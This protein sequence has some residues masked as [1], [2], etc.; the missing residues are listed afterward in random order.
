MASQPMFDHL[1]RRFEVGI[2]LGVLDVEGRSPLDVDI[3]LARGAVVGAATDQD[4]N[5]VEQMFDGQTG[6][7]AGGV[8]QADVEGAFDQVLHQ[9]RLEADFAADRDVA[10]LAPHPVQPGRQ[11]AVPERDAPANAERSAIAAGQPDVV[12]CLFGGQDQTFSVIGETATAGGQRGTG[13]I[14]H[15]QAD[16][17]FFLKA[18]D[19]GAHCRLRQMQAVGRLEKTAVG[20]DGQKSACLVDVHVAERLINRYCRYLIQNNIA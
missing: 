2:A 4:K 16:A 8:H 12:P 15:E 9:V 14:A 18:L 19:A 13:A 17:E 6:A 7:V 11:Q 5:F 1:R 3:V 10:R 20:G